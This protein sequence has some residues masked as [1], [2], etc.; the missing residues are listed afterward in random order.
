MEF[1][2]AGSYDVVVIGLGHAGVEAALASARL[3]CKTLAMCIPTDLSADG[4][5]FFADGEALI[6]IDKYDLSSAHTR[7]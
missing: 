3:G 4:I 6:D 5:C 2:V 1:Y 7:L